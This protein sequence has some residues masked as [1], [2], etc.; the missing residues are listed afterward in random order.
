MLRKEL[1]SDRGMKVD[2]VMDTANST[3]NQNL[4]WPDVQE[5]TACPFLSI[6]YAGENILVSHK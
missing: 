2:H 4:G 5:N 6:L 3:W 1:F